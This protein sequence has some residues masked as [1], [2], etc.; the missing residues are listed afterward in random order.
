MATGHCGLNGELAPNS[1][2]V[3][4]MRD[5]ETVAIQNHSMEVNHALVKE[6]N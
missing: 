1:V 5:K 2:V 4:L 6:Q 3:A